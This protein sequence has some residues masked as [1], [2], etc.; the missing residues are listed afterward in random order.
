METDDRVK[1]REF[2]SGTRLDK[3][4]YPRIDCYLNQTPSPWASGSGS[5]K[6][7]KVNMVKKVRDYEEMV[8]ANRKL[9]ERLTKTP[10]VYPRQ[11]MAKDWAESES[12]RSRIS[13]KR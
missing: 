6:A 8:E 13:Q 5:I 4:Q 9:A 10:S 1:A 3:N 2:T 11:K 12:L 7:G